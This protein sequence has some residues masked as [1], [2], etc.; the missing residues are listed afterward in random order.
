MTNP[1]RDVA[2]AVRMGSAEGS[3]RRRI[4][5]VREADDV[6]WGGLEDDF[7][8][9]EVRLRHDGTTVTRVDMHAVR[10]PWVTCADAGRN[11]K[12][13]SN[14]GWLLGA[15]A[16]GVGAYFLLSSGPSSAPRTTV[17]LATDPAGGRLAFTRSF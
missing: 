12:T 5:L 9:F 7:H 1:G 13:I 6:V 2:P 10:W 11:L 3:Y 16:L 15:S 4:R 8:H 14:V 17:S